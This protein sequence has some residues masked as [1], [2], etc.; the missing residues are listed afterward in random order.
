MKDTWCR[1]NGE[2]IIKQEG[3]EKENQQHRNHEAPHS[4]LANALN[5]FAS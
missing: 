1:Q 2:P 5:L 3:V 4:V